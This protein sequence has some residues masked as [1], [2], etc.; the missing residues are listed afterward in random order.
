MGRITGCLLLLA[1]LLCRSAVAAPSPYVAKDYSAILGMPGISDTT[2]QNH[3]KLYQGYVNNTN[4]LWQ[5]TRDLVTQGKGN[6][7]EFAEMRRRLGFEFNGMRLHEFYF[8]NLKGNGTPDPNSRIYR[9]LAE[10]FG[11]V[12]AWKQD[13][14]DTGKLRGIGWAILYYDP[15][16]HRLLNVWVDEHQINNL[17]GLV[18]ILVMDVWEHAYYLDYQ[19]NR[20]GY[21]DAFFANLNW[22]VVAQRFETVLAQR[23]AATP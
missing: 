14:L 1:C 9:K 18:P 22:P 13:F 10:D 15:M 8:E 21:L 6:T 23:P 11:S 20:P 4:T 12:D 3:F 19:T 16:H 5:K 2:L 7:P 17:A